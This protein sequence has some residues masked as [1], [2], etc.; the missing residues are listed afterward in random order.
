MPE[1]MPENFQ[2]RSSSKV[3]KMVNLEICEALIYKIKGF[4]L[5]GKLRFL[6]LILLLWKI[7]YSP[8][9]SVWMYSLVQ[10]VF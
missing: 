6:C 5:N 4:Y 7:G 2:S 9:E 10:Q 8:V 3:L 1:K